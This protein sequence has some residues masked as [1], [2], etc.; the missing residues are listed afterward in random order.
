MLPKVALVL[1]K[2]YLSEL[3]NEYLPNLMPS[4][5]TIRFFSSNTIS[6]ASLATST[7]S[8]TDIP[9]IGCVECRYIINSIAHICNYMPDAWSDFI[10]LFLFGKAPLLQNTSI[11]P[12]CAF[13][14]SVVIFNISPPVIILQSLM[15]LLAYIGSY[16]QIIAGYYLSPTPTLA[17]LSM[18]SCTPGFNGSSNNSNPR[19]TISFSSSFLMI[20]L[21]P[22]AL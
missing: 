14:A 7:A 16:M 4:Y 17:S 8:L 11:A 3:V 13:N 1:M 10:I 22:S 21:L 6:A 20:V 5:S 9:A 18:A 12:A 15:Q 2:I 19:N